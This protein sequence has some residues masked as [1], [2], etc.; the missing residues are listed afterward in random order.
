MS[1]CVNVPDDYVVVHC[2]F[3]PLYRFEKFINNL[4]HAM[5]LNVNQVFFCMSVLSGV[6]VQSQKKDIFRHIPLLYPD[7][8]NSPVLFVSA[9]EKFFQKNPIKIE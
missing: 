9:K 5:C 4:I 2:V 1:V 6:L 8:S 3:A 7:V